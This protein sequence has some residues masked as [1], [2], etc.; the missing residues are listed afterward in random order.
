MAKIIGFLL[1]LAWV[2]GK[3]DNKIDGARIHKWFDKWWK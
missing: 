1:I 3:V 2:M